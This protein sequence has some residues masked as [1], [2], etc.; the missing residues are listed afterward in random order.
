[1]NEPPG[2]LLLLAF[3]LLWVLVCVVISHVGGWHELAGSYRL[4]QPLP[5]TVWRFQSAQMRW[6]MGYNNCL[7]VGADASGLYL[8]MLFFFR[9][10]HPPLFIRWSEMTVRQRKV[11]FVTMFELRFQSVPG[12]PLIVRASLAD[13]LR[14]RAGAHW[15][16]ERVEPT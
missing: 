5:E 16:V 1:M 12:V 13:R 15:P 10:G 8:A 14:S 3:P 4:E 9:P 11:F 6:L 7:T 2:A